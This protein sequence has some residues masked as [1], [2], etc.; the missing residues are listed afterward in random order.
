MIDIGEDTVLVWGSGAIGSTIGAHLVQ[1]GWPV[2][3]VDI[4]DPHLACIRNGAL[5]IDGPVAQLSVGA[6]AG[7]PEEIAG[8]TRLILFA[9]RL[10][11]MAEALPGALRHLSDDGIIVS[12]Q[13]GLGALDVAAAAGADRTVA[14]SFF[15]PADFN[16]PGHVTYASRARMSIGAVEKEA[17]PALSA[18]L[19]VLRDF[20]SE[21][22]VSEDILSVIW[23]KMAYGA[24]LAAAAMDDGVTARFLRN[25]RLRPLLVALMKEVVG[26][27]RASGHPA[28]DASWFA[29]NAF[30]SD[31][32][33]DHQACIDSVLDVLKTSAKQ[34]SGPWQQI[35]LQKKRTEIVPQFAPMIALADRHGVGVPVTR[36]LLGLIDDMENQR[37]SVG[38]DT[39]DVL[40]QAV[41]GSVS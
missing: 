29:P 34:H 31:N 40:V 15:L 8:R 13:N 24:L 21:V 1:A 33:R 27:A 14:A 9:I 18:V 37:R 5:G 10:Y 30:L 32:P 7:R 28:E 23:T 16:G 6:P 39:M 26:V 35:V 19:A 11:D 2:V 3:F 36:C 25:E 12:C 38:P 22:H 41:H 17:A 20:E 4:N